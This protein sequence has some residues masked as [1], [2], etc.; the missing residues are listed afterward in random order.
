MRDDFFWLNTINRATVVVGCRNKQFDET[1]ARRAA[2]GIKAVEAAGQA[3][4]SKRVKKY[5]AWEPMFIAAAGPE[6]TVIH[7]G[8][9][10]QDILS[11]V[12][13]A[14]LRDDLLEFAG[15][16]ED[17]IGALLELARRHR[18]TIVPS[19]TNGVPRS[20]P[21]TVIPSRPWPLRSCAPVCACSRHS[22]RLMP[23]PWARPS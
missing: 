1:L 13:A 23:A 7:A 16:L 18:D 10:S 14:M 2:R 19:Y 15:A 12:R 20:P 22:K 11:T 3:D 9:S 6:V 21:R 17:V 4:P 8:R 5:I